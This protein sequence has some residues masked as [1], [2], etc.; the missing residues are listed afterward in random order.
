MEEISKTT[1]PNYK[2]GDG[3]Q[4]ARLAFDWSKSKEL[5]L[6]EK[7]DSEINPEPGIDKP[8]EDNEPKE[9]K[10]TD[11]ESDKSAENGQKEYDSERIYIDGYPDGTF[12]PDNS[13]TRAEAAKVL[14]LAL[15]DNFDQNK[16]FDDNFRDVESD[17][18]YAKVIGYL[19]SIDAIDGYEDGT[20]KADK[21]ITRA[22]FAKIIAK[23]DGL[24]DSSEHDK[25]SDVEAKHWAKGY[26]ENI[27]VKGYIVGYPD[28]TFKA[29]NSITR[30]EVVTIVNRMLKK[31]TDSI[32]NKTENKFNDITDAHWAFKDV[33]AATNMQKTNK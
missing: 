5:E 14:A 10:D 27:A 7:P 31:N 22:E 30:A 19:K 4:N 26:I 15:T 29:E 17:A 25:F 20:F 28:G 13:I 32:S 24:S 1:N 6:D 11:K 23:I 9:S 16:S 8:V 12:R 21:N 2:P 33:L 18:W 3:E